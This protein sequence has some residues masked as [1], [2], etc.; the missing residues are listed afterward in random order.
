[1]CRPA[2]LLAGKTAKPASP[3]ILLNRPGRFARRGS[4]GEQTVQNIYERGIR[5]AELGIA[6]MR[7]RLYAQVG[8]N[9]CLGEMSVSLNVIDRRFCW[10]V[11][12]NNDKPRL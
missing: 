10:R 11:C 1:M 3:K 7:I 12:I 8:G 2:D 6:D 9:D 4:A 5:I